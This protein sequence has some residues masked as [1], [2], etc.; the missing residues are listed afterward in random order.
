[1]R[2]VEC[3]AVSQFEDERTQPCFDLTYRIAIK[4]PERIIDLGCGPGNSSRVLRDRWPEAEIT[5]LDNSDAMI[6]K[7]RQSGLKVAGLS[8]IFR[9][10]RLPAPIALIFFSQTPRCTG[11][12][13]IRSCFLYSSSEQM[14]FLR[15]RCRQTGPAKITR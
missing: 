8:A 11:C 9:N 12:R 3:S 6:E 5:G 10:G 15:C 1:M 13:I 7:A 14:P 2:D 4:Q